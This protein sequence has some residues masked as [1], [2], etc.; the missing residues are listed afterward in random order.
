MTIEEIKEKYKFHIF[1]LY[2]IK[3]KKWGCTLELKK[4]LQKQGYTIQ[5]TEEVKQVIG[6]QV[7]DR[8][9]KFLNEREGYSYNHTQSYINALYKR[10][11]A[12]KK[13][14]NYKNRKKVTNHNR[15]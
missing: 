5:D 11:L 4:R 8:L 1:Y 9:E 15:P 14:K 10:C 3:G 12:S 6:I 13:V 2:H 7:A